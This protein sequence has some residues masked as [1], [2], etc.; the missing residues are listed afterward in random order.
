MTSAL[1]AFETRVQLRRASF[2]FALVL[3]IAPALSGL[4]IQNGRYASLL[5]GYGYLASLALRLRLGM[6]EDL[7]SGQDLLMSNFAPANRR[8]AVKLGTL[9]IR[10]VLV[11]V[12]AFVVATIV[13]R[14][15]RLGLWYS[16]EFALIAC[17]LLPLAAAAELITGTKAPGAVALLVAGAAALLAMQQTDPVRVLGWV[18]IPS[19]AG[20]WPQL[21]RLATR[22]L[23]GIV[24]LCA[25]AAGWVLARGETRA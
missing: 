3:L 9:A 23:A 18:G 24:M 1:L 25:C 17:V 13:W 7:Q 5:F 16:L 10:E 12:L 21:A 2:R 11:L 20:S 15:A 8:I 14:S 19:S 4:L 6:A 22:G